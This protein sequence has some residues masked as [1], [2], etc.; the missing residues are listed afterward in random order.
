MLPH[1][2]T[3]AGPVADRLA[4]MVSTEADL[5]MIF[6][7]YDGGGATGRAVAGVDRDDPLVDVTTADGVR[8]RV[9]AITDPEVLAEIAADL[10][11]R[12]AVIADGHHR[13]ATY[14]QYQARRHAAGDGPGPWDF[15]LAFLV[16]GSAFGPQVHAIHRAVPGLTADRAIELARDRLRGRPRSPAGCGPQRTR[17]PRPGSTG[18]P[19]W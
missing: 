17:W 19:S 16:D 12:R 11:G 4:L 1:E 2:N 5:E 6:L 18:S 14:L 7:V 9:W 3:M 13:Y 15:G 10:H 8:H